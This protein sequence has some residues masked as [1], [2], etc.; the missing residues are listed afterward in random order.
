ML[1]IA[2]IT[3]A[4]SGAGAYTIAWSSSLADATSVIWA[5]PVSHSVALTL[6]SH[7][8]TLASVPCTVLAVQAL[9]M[10]WFAVLPCFPLTHSLHVIVDSVSI[11]IDEVWA[12]RSPAG[13][14]GRSS[15]LR[16]Q[17]IGTQDAK[18]DRQQEAKCR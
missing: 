13:I 6:V 3:V 16:I 9:S 7:P 17:I 10:P 12:E 8:R 15:I 18:S 11:F 14:D 5:C 1:P 4:H 2:G